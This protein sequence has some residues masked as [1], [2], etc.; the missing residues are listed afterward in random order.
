MT[1]DVAPTERELEV[2][3]ANGCCASVCLVLGAED[4]AA[5]FARVSPWCRVIRV[6]V[7]PTGGAQAEE[8]CLLRDPAELEKWLGLRGGTS[9]SVWPK[10]RRKQDAR[11]YA[12]A[13]L[14][15]LRDVP[16]VDGIVCAVTRALLDLGL[17][18]TAATMEDAQQLLGA[19]EEAAARVLLKLDGKLPATRGDNLMRRNDERREKEA[20]QTT[21]EVI[22]QNILIAKSSHKGADIRLSQGGPL[23]PSQWPRRSYE[24]AMWNWKPVLSYSW[25]KRRAGNGVAPAEH[26]NVLEMR[27][28]LSAVRYKAR[29]GGLR[30]RWLHLLDSQV[31]LSVLAK[32]RSSSRRLAGVVEGIS[33]L[34]LITG[35]SLYG[36]YV[37]TDHNPA[38]APS[39][40]RMRVRKT[41]TKHGGH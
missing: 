33:A 32:G 12:S 22:L 35:S 27:A 29:R 26:I 10:G 13:R 17:L 1:N 15:I 7:A 5:R 36:G 19:D 23:D 25:G 41:I 8:R 20:N 6:Q 40:K 18:S 11:G 37:N 34:L 4:T 16:R 30:Q 2:F 28:A 14:A 39:R 3:A 21:E 24:A 31:C 9:T 38:D